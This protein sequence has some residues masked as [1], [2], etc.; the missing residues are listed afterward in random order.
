MSR[1][2]RRHLLA[3]LAGLVAV[4]M[5][6]APAAAQDDPYGGTSTTRPAPGPRPT[7]RVKPDSVTPG[8]T[9]VARVNAVPRGS[10]V[11]VTFDGEQ[12]AEAQADGP[13]SSPHVNIDIPYTV[14]D[15]E[16][17]S[18]E[19]TA[20]G[21]TFTASC[22]SQRV[23]GEVLGDQIE[24]D[25]DGSGG[26]VL[27]GSLPA[28]GLTVGLLVAVAVALILGGRVLLDR[29]RKRGQPTRF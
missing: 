27:G 24:R 21:A 29:S 15:V 5:L 20:V 16:P 28:T 22:G 10:T 19:V 4:L 13:G 23:E 1:A 2:R 3:M 8:S 25:P 14:P 6:A 18:Y 26:G 12:V 7:C 11:R 9:A 17:G